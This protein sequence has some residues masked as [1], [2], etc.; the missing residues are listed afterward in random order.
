MKFLI[1][2]IVTGG[3]LVYL[4]LAG[5]PE[6]TAVDASRPIQ[7]ASAAVPAS[8]DIRAD[9]RASE[10]QVPEIQPAETRVA[11]T[12][13]AETRATEIKAAARVV[14]EP[15][16]PPIPITTAANEPVVASASGSV[17][18]PRSENDIPG[19][20]EAPMMSASDRSRMLRD[21]ARDM[22]TRFL[23]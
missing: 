21:L 23:Q 4:V 9:R 19:E 22:E 1:F 13:A 6:V 2:N 15:P 7:T 14:K 8:P 17:S 18:S 3:A 10:A 16:L 5:G 20:V 11:E 12:R